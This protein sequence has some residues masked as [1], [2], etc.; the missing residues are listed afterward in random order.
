MNINKGAKVGIVIEII[1]LV[2]M[3]LTAIFNRTIPSVVSWI[4]TIGL[5]IALTGTIV[6]L[7]IE[8]NKI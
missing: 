4:F 2:I 8:N 3:I 6:D 1:A 5:T 7:S